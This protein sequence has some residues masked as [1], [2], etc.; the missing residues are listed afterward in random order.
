[1]YAENEPVKKRNDAVLKDLSGELYTIEADDKIPDNCRYPLATIQA[2]QNQNQRN[3][4]GLAKF[5]KLEVGAKVMLTVNLD[6][7]DRLIN[8]HTG[9]TSHS[10]F[11]QGSI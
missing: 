7:Q 1:M 8:G 2:A 3:A 10:E 11:A 6:I 5:L 9:N 4:G